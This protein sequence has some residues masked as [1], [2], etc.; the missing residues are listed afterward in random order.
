MDRDD[1][2]IDGMDCSHARG[3]RRVR[4][5]VVEVFAARFA[6]NEPVYR[7]LAGHGD[8]RCDG[9]RDSASRPSGSPPP[10]SSSPDRWPG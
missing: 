6:R 1:S 7:F 4:P 8:A 2:P 3:A 5:V 9:P 10:C